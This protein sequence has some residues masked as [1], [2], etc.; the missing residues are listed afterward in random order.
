MMLQQI[1]R[2]ARCQGG[3]AA[4]ATRIFGGH[5]AFSSSGD[6]VLVEKKPSAVAVLTLNRPKA[7]NA[8]SDGLM[9]ELV[10]KLQDLESDDTIRA[11]VVTGT[12][13]A[14]AAGADIKKMGSRAGYSDVRQCNMLEH[15]SGV[16]SFRKPI[17]AAV[18]GFALGGGCELAMSCDI[19]IA[20]AEAKFGQ[21]EIKLGTIPG[22]GGT[23]R[24]I[25]AVGKSRAMELIL[26]GDV[27][28]AEEADRIGLARLVPAGQALEEALKVAEKIAAFSAPVAQ[29]AKECVN[30][31][32][33][34]SLTEGLRFERN[35]FH[36]TW[37]LEDRKEGFGA[38][39][40]KRQAEFKHK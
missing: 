6:L 20:S 23:Q 24:L 28:S 34:T 30:A 13:K 36:A 25:R 19:I 33:E 12:G 40:E 1:Q 17:I 7:L 14:F 18:N 27:I 8:L 16:S 32:E 31:A 39:S 3:K 15:W 21:P 10:Q 35:L 2:A 5:R 38:F 26:T 29:L 22:V 4:V 37:G 11:A 9:F